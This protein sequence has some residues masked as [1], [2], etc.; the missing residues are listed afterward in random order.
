MTAGRG[1]WVE[2]QK[3]FAFDW[4]ALR[5]ADFH[6]DQIQKLLFSFDFLAAQKVSAQGVMHPETVFVV[7]DTTDTVRRSI[8]RFW[9]GGSYFLR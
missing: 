7:F 2:G 1:V 6:S 3:R 9:V 5:R 8:E 4:G